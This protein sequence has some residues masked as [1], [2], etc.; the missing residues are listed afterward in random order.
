MSGWVKHRIRYLR[1]W[2]Q[3]VE[4]LTKSIEE[5]LPDTEVYVIGGAA[6]D[7]LTILSDIDVLI[8]VD[9]PLT[10]QQRRKI[11]A[12]IIW[13]AEKHGFPWDYPVEIH[14]ISRNELPQ[15]LKHVKKLVPVKTKTSQAHEISK[16]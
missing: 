12:D 11:K 8:V 5:L 6:E 10:I 4:A 7:R 16:Q 14:I 2:R 13:N 1:N 3:Y 9:E 15:Y